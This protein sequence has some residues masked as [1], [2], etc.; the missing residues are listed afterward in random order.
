MKASAPDITRRRRR[1]ATLVELLTALAVSMI[2]VAAMA[3]AFIQIIRASDE[4]QAQV[5]ASNSARLAVDAVSTELATLNFTTPGQ[6]FFLID[7]P[8]TYGDNIDN[9][10]DTR[11]DE[12]IFNG[13]DDDT[14]WDVINDD[15]HATIGTRR[16]RN[17]GVGIA[18]YGD[19]HVDE[20]CLFS[21]DEISWLTPASI[22]ASGTLERIHYGIGTFEGE[23]NVLL[24]T[25][26]V[27]YG[28]INAIETVE[29]I[30]FEVLSF[31]VLAWNSNSDSPLAASD[32]G[33]WVSSWLSSGIVA[34]TYRPLGAPAG[35]PPFELPTSFLVS[36][37]V[38][39]ER[40]PLSDLPSPSLAS[41]PF[42]T[43]RASTV[44][45]VESTLLDPRYT[46][47]VRDP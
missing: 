28:T 31:D 29:P 37:V 6:E 15:R 22:S 16:E 42:R 36:V 40:S 41:R 30:V 24:R 7:R 9:D 11:T 19:G 1:A 32:S 17:Y 25:S 46:S 4:A 39:A 14:D 26:T 33:Y 2:L 34:P 13:L 5:R 35:T 3:A 27:N 8:L 12:E 47:F 21:A 38:S 10:T 18:D 45:D 20:D 44:V 43:L 23:S